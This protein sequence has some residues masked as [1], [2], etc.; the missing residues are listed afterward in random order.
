MF[1]ETQRTDGV[2]TSDIVARI[3]KNYSD[4]S[5]QPQPISNVSTQTHIGLFNVSCI[6]CIYFF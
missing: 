4:F 2:S 3:I 6:C 5:D 1:V